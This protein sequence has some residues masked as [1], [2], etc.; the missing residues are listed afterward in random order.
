MA[1]STVRNI[2]LSARIYYF[3]QQ[4]VIPPPQKKPFHNTVNTSVVDIII[5]VII[6][7]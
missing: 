5:C 2:V 3:S 7:V 4:T 1:T 6:H